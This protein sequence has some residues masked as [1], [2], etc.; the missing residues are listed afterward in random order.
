MASIVIGRTAGRP[1][2]RA[3]VRAGLV[4]VSALAVLAGLGGL[5]WLLHEVATGPLTYHYA[6]YG[7]LGGLLAL[8]TLHRL[9][10][11]VSLLPAAGH[12]RLRVIE[13]GRTTESTQFA[14][15]RL[16]RDRILTVGRALD[17][18][19]R[20]SS[21]SVSRQ[22]C[23]VTLLRDGRICVGDRGSTN[24]TLVDGR[25]L[26]PGETVVVAPGARLGVGGGVELALTVADTGDRAGEDEDE[27]GSRP[28][29]RGTALLEWTLLLLA[30]SA[31]LSLL[32][33]HHFAMDTLGIEELGRLEAGRH[34]HPLASLVSETAVLGRF[35]F[36]ACLAAALVAVKQYALPGTSPVVLPTVT[37]LGLVGYLQMLTLSPRLSLRHPAHAGLADRHLG[38]LAFSLLAATALL[39]FYRHGFRYLAAA[40]RLAGGWIRLPWVLL[41]IVVAATIAFGTDLGTGKYLWLGFGGLTLQGL[42]LCKVLLL[43]GMASYFH[44]FLPQLRRHPWRGRLLLA[45]CLLT[46]LVLVGKQR[47]MG[48]LLFLSLF[49]LA[50]YLHVTGET[51]R[52]LKAGLALAVLVGGAYAFLPDWPYT[53][54]VRTRVEK[55]LDPQHADEQL[56]LA[57]ACV[58]RGGLTGVGWGLG[59]A[60]RV[61]PA[62]QSDFNAVSL[63]EEI[64]F[65]GVSLVLLVQFLLFWALLL[66]P[67]PAGNTF[68]GLF[69]RGVAL[70]LGLQV[71]VIVAGD[72]ALI[73]LAGITLP[74]VSHGGTS[75]VVCV[76]LV[77]LALVFSGG[78]WEKEKVTW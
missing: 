36:L 24:G 51:G 47:D 74:F 6:F 46:T 29:P 61:V 69:P 41:W 75:L 72:L 15:P 38:A 23:E 44:A 13:R 43:V 70:M 55:C 56:T 40:T 35:V 42:E 59:E 64:G 32:R 20:L 16:A 34:G 54:I 26:Q 11:A 63:A 60:A 17:A 49:A 58:A 21:V 78:R 7:C 77:A 31:G 18:D 57:T 5:A 9:S 27:D 53:S 4:T 67:A 10:H 48:G 39:L 68:L 14:F 71:L 66:L 3:L 76:L 30:L 1:V 52:V 45:G 73:P 22:H 50:F 25:R 37:A 19:V 33:L 2:A 62:V 65:V 28:A 8:G 12:A